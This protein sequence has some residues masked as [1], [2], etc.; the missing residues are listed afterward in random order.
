MFSIKLP[1]KLAICKGCSPY[2]LPLGPSLI[3]ALS[4]VAKA[5]DIP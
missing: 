2:N 5:L 4:K 3:V 1:L